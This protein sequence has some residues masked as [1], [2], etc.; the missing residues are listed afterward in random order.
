MSIVEPPAGRPPVPYHRLART[1]K[2]RWWRPVLGTLLVLGGTFAAMIAIYLAIVIVGTAAGRP[3]GPEGVP[4]FGP[5][6]DTAFLLVSLA[7]ATPFVLLAARWVQGRP[8]G[9]VSSVL[10]RLRWR[11][12]SVCLLIAL[13]VILLML[14]TAITLF[15][16]TG[17]SLTDDTEHWVGTATFAAGAIMVLL[18]V[19]FQAAAEEY[20]FRGWLLQ[21]VGAFFRTPWFPA[22]VQAL[23]FAAVHGWG[24]AWGFADLTVFG[25]V[26][27][28]LA[29]RTG[30]IEAGIAL[31]VMNNLVVFLIS[32]AIGD[33]A[34]DETSADAPWQLFVATSL[35]NITYAAMIAWL[36]RRKR[37][38]TT[39]PAG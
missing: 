7:V 16:L 20:V 38:A 18:L 25:L 9:T 28:W 23:L 32:A 24:T 22:L 17:E 15:A 8:A 27:A 21:A 39:T 4:T 1:E 31:H 10:G 34:S 26:L 5:I 12:L 29:V 37:I 14:G 36:A 6:A 3:N 2:H 33:L 13:P 30:G 35:A 19:P 11:W